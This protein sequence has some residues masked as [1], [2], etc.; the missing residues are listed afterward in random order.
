MLSKK[1]L[2]VIKKT[3]DGIHYT[4][5][6]NISISAFPLVFLGLFSGVIS[7]CLD[8]FELSLNG[9]N[10]ALVS[11]SRLGNLDGSLLYF[12]YDRCCN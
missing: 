9:I 6:F 4:A 10:V 5:L 12:Y 2:S 11:F 1:S 8:V 3:R 7:A